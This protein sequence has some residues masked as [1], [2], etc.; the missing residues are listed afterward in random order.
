MDMSLSDEASQ[1]GK[2]VIFKTLNKVA[3]VNE[4][5]VFSKCEITYAICRILI[6]HVE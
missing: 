2:R 4:A 5:L 3:L 6:S 1:L